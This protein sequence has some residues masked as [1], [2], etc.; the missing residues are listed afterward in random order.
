MNVLVE[1]VLV[2]IQMY[3]RN[4]ETADNGQ[5]FSMGG[6]RFCSRPHALKWPIA[7]VA[8]IRSEAA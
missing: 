6:G 5:S 2:W 3:T 8:Q 1:G 4:F 7:A